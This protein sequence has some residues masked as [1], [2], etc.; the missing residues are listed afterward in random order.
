MNDEA[1]LAEVD[2]RI[3]RKAPAIRVETLAGAQNLVSD[4]PAQTRPSLVTDQNPK[5]IGKRSRFLAVTPVFSDNPT[6]YVFTMLGP[7]QDAASN[8]MLGGIKHGCEKRCGCDALWWR[9]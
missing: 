5:M 8:R 1:S 2:Q 6:F 7:C 4:Q 9:G 3:D